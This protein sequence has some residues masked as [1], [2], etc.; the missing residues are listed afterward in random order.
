M[1]LT[2]NSV[3][4]IAKGTLLYT[5][6]KA[7]ESVALVVKGRVLVYNTGT[8]IVC[9]P[10]SFIG[11]SDLIVGTY[12]A[13]AY[14][15]EDAQVFPISVHNLEEMEELLEGRADYR[16]TVVTAL[17][18]Q[19]LELK[20]DYDALQKGAV[21]LSN[22]LK[23]SYATYQELGKKNSAP[24]SKLEGIEHMEEIQ[25]PEGSEDV[26]EQ[27]KYYLEC[28][29]LPVEIQ[30]HYYGHGRN[31]A[32][33]HMEEQISIVSSMMEYCELYANYL[34][35]MFKNLACNDQDCL[36]NLS[37]Q[38]TLVMKKMKVDTSAIMKMIH[39]I[40]EHMK[41]VETVIVSR[42]GKK[43]D[44]DKE[45]ME[46]IFA[47]I[48]DGAAEVEED[49][50]E[51]SAETAV[52]YAGVDIE[53]IE[54]ETTG[55]LKKIMD[56]SGL[57]EEKCDEFQKYVLAFMNLKD[58][59]ST[60]DDARTIRRKL[61]SGFYDL[62]EAVFKRDFEEKSKNRII[63]LFLTYGFVDE[64]LLSKEQLIQLYCL[65]DQND[66]TGRCK[67]YN[68]KQWLSAVWNGEKEPSK[69]EFDMDYNETLR[70]MKKSGQLTDEQMKL[71]MEDL[72]KKF[73]YEVRN[74]FKYNS[75]VV[76]GQ[77]SVF[78]PILYRDEFMGHLDQS[79]MTTNKVNQ[80]IDKIRSID[81]SV[82]YREAMQ[83]DPSRGIDKEY[84][85][86]EYYPDV[87]LLPTYG[88]NGAMWQEIE[89]RKRS[90]HARF[91]VPIFA[92]ADMEDVF[93]RMCGRFRWELCRTVQGA[94]WNDVKVKSLTSEYVDYIQ[95]YKKNRALSDERKEKLKMQIQK[96]RGNTREVFVID[97][98]LWV[99]NECTGSM[100]MNKV[101]R[102]ILANYCPF[103][104]EIRDKLN[105][106]PLYEEAMARFHRERLKKVKELDLRYRA[107]ETKGG[108]LSP[109]LE[110]T[111]A[112]F[113]DM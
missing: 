23:R 43:V 60:D 106:Q 2:M 98:L 70:D 20:R 53:T 21:S 45:K 83:N 57:P 42:S 89:G 35:D 18:R 56:Y 92:E 95:F 13:N 27:V 44:L 104:K 67:V 41:E 6:T 74:M 93:I 110:H 113:K 8:K 105:S 50:D 77:L 88:S 10:G 84:I 68:S 76:S 87:V 7:V 54:R 111:L 5:Q 80:I 108:S 39:E 112:F 63:D 17:S 96:G 40:R 31:I 16:S 100:R 64:R 11:V 81:F 4:A 97:Y 79:L 58:K 15:M 28:V 62:Y 19:I 55:S 26:L 86:E 103:V 24:I 12:S 109:E 30:K 78:V 102:E 91:L 90:S 61:T 85:Q 29:T 38:M 22:F 49:D 94:A 25:L 65:E 71:D 47:M 1:G 46:Q 3:N 48:A 36:Y 34:L 9:G 69:S 66:G 59:A 73:E 75:K 14:V 72:T 37:V 32:V 51:V 107:I 33:R 52:R 82:F 101:A 99:K